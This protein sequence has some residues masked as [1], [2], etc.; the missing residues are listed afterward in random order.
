M[1]AALIALLAVSVIAPLGSPGLGMGLVVAGSFLG[2]GTLL[3]G[4]CLLTGWIGARR[5][6]D[7]GMTR[8]PKTGA[9]STRALRT[10]ADSPRLPA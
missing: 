6:A 4:S 9:A 1:Q 10:E 3:F 8:A 5:V 7:P 2:A